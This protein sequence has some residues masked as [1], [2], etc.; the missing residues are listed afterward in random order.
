MLLVHQSIVQP[1]LRKFNEEA[2]A[3]TPGPYSTRPSYSR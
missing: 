3:L 1:F 2:A